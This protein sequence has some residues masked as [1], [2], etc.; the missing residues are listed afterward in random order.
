[1]AEQGADIIDIGGESTRPGSGRVSA[2]DQIAR[3]VPVIKALNGRLT[4]PISV[5]TTLSEVA[6]AAF[7]VGAS[8]INDISAFEDDPKMAVTAASLGCPAI[9]TH[10]KG[11]PA[12]MQISPEYCDVVGEV[13]GYLNSRIEYALDSGIN[14]DNIIIDPGIGFGKT[15]EHNLQL[16]RNLSCFCEFGVPILLG[17]SR[18]S[19]IGKILSID[20]PCQRIYGDLAVLAIA[21]VQG[22][23][24]FRVHEV[25]PA[26]EL[27]K[28]LQAI[29]A[30]A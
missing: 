3:I 21:R 9:I 1:M 2:A 16:I 26:V 10:K 27:L 13:R 15:V 14:K 23:N 19:F 22:A 30:P 11:S 29:N 18:K 4:V 24:I 20:E 7:D 25:R 17:A 5:D 6:Q 28:M 8:V 12:N